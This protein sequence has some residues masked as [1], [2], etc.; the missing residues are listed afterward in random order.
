VSE[1]VCVKGV[2]ECVS[3]CVCVNGSV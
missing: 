1:C 2:H 3:E